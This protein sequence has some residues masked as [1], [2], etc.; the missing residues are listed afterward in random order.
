MQL[1]VIASGIAT[2]FAGATFGTVEDKSREVAIHQDNVGG[3]SVTRKVFVP[4]GG[5]F[6]RYLELLTNPADAPATVDVRVSSHVLRNNGS[7]SSPAVITTSSGDD[8]LDVTDP[9][10]AIAGS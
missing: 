2:R 7:D 1:D 10:R 6:A 5:Y 8:Q 3:L 9:S 4:A